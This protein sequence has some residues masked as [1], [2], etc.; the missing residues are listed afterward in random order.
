M[1]H[2]EASTAS[3]FRG[4]GLRVANRVYVYPKIGKTLGQEACN[5]GYHRG[6]GL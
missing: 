6:H 4:L 1:A 5:G 2:V 3:R